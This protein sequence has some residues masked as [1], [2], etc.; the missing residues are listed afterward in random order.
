MHLRSRRNIPSVALLAGTILLLLALAPAAVAKPVKPKPAKA[1]PVSYRRL[2]RS[3]ECLR[4]FTL[5]GYLDG[6]RMN[7]R[8]VARRAV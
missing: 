1:K 7:L 2:T 5:L 3:G 6:R 8:R 4:P